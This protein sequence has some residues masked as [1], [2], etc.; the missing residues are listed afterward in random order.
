MKTFITI[1][2]T[3]LATIVLFLLLGK[4]GM[5][6]NNAAPTAQCPPSNTVIK[7][8]ETCTPPTTGT[9]ATGTTA[10]TI[11]AYMCMGDTVKDKSPA[12]Q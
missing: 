1:L 9:Q 11:S 2:T 4:N 3:A 8:V 10:Q 12:M 7:T 5:I 6:G